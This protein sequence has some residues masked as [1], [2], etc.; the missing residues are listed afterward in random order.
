ME[1]MDYWERRYAQGGTSG[2]GS[3]ARLAEFKAEVLNAFVQERHIQSVIEFGCGDGNQLSLARYPS[4]VGL[5]VSKTAIF[6]CGRRFAMDSDKSFFLYAPGC[7]FDR[8]GLFYADLGVSLSNFRLGF[9][10]N[11][12]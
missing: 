5:D 11:S 8:A 7:F 1:S 12:L 4:Y 10:I 3:Y 6:L 9:C 2:S